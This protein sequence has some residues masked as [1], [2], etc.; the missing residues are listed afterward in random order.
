[1]ARC[2]RAEPT[3][4]SRRSCPGRRS[5]ARPRRWAGTGPAG[6]GRGVGLDVTA[7]QVAELAHDGH[8]GA[9][10]LVTEMGTRLGTGIANLVNAFTPEGVA[11]G[12]GV[13]ALGDLLLDPAREEV[14]RRALP[15]SCDLVRIVPT[16]F[17]AES[18]MLGAAVMAFEG[19]ATPP[20]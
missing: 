17:G 8:A 20:T 13:L 5:R 19:L 15:P 9:R 10:A 2:A 12:G 18:G 14:K 7:S 4:A 3:A 1:M 11:V 6:G 16:H